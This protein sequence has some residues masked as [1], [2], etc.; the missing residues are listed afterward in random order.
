MVN[1]KLDGQYADNSDWSNAQGGAIHYSTDINNYENGNPDEDPE[2]RIVNSTIADNS[3]T[4]ISEN[5]DNVGG[6]GICRNGTENH[7]TTIFNSIIYGNEIEGYLESQNNRINLSSY[8]SPFGDNGAHINYSILEFFEETGLD[9]DDLMDTDPNFVGSGNYTLSNASVAIGAGIDEYEDIDAPAFDYNNSVRPNPDGSDPDLGAFESSLST[10]PYPATPQNLV[11][12]LEADSSI[13]LSWTAN[14]EDDLSEYR[15][16]YGTSSATALLDSVS[17]ANTYEAEGLDNYTTYYFAVSAMDLDGYESSKSNEVSG[18]PKWS[19]PIWY[20]DWNQSSGSGKDGSPATPFRELQDAIDMIA[21]G[22][23]IIVLPGTYNRT[24]DTELS[25]L[26]DSYQPKNLVLQSRDGAA[27]TILD[28]EDK[29]VFDISDGTDTT[30]QIIGFT[31]TAS[32]GGEDDAD[33]SVIKI[34]GDSYNNNNQQIIEYSGVTFKNCIIKDVDGED[35]PIEV[36]YGKAIFNDCEI[37]G[38][39]FNADGYD[40]DAIGGAIRIGA[41]YSSGSSIVHFYRSKLVNNTVTADQ[42]QYVHGGAIGIGGDDHDVKLVNTIVAGNSINFNSSNDSYPIG[43]GGIK[44]RGGNLLLINCTIADNQVNG[45]VTWSDASGSAIHVEDYLQDDNPTKLTIFNSIIY[46]NTTI[47][48]TSSSSVTDHNDQIY[49]NSDGND[50]AD[51]YASYS[52]FGGDDDLDGDEILLNTFPDFTDTTY[53]LHERS[54]AIGKGAT[55]SVD[56]EDETIYAPSNDLAGN[57]R[58]G[59]GGGDPDLGAY[60]HDLAVTPY[61]APLENLTA[62]PLHQSVLL[63]WDLH[64]ENNVDSYI[65]YISEDSITFTAVDTVTSRFTVNITI[66]N[67][68]NDEDYWFYVTAVN[69]SDYESLPSFHTKTTPF[70]QGPV[71]YVDTDNGSSS[72]DGSSGEPVRE[73]QDAIDIAA[74][75]DTVLVLPGTYDRADD[76]ELYFKYTSG[77]NDGDPKNIVLKSRDGAAVTILDGEGNKSLFEITDETD[78]TLQIIGFTIYNGGGDGEYNSSG[79]AVQIL[80]GGGGPSGVTFRNCIFTETTSENPVIYGGD[81][82]VRFFDCEIKNNTVSNNSWT[83][84]VIYFGSECNVF[85]NRCKITDNTTIAGDWAYGGAMFFKGDG[86]I[87]NVKVINSIIANNSALVENSPGSP[88]L[89]GAFCIDWGGVNVTV[90]NCTIVGNTAD[91]DDG[92]NESGGVASIISNNNPSNFTVLNSIMTDNYPGNNPFNYD[93]NTELRVSYSFITGIDDVG[94]YEDG[95]YNFEPDFL[96]STYALHPRS[97]AIGA[98]EVEEEDAEGNEI[99]A[100][101]IDLLGNARPN[102]ADSNPDLGAYEHELAVTA[103]PAIVEDVT[104]TPFHRSVLVEWDYHEE[105]DVTS[106]IAYMSSDLNTIPFIAIDTVEGRFNTRTTIENLTNG[107][108]YWFYVTAVDTAGYES[109]PTLFEQTSPFFQGPVWFVD[110]ANGSSNAE[111]SPE[112]PLTQIQDAID[113][114]AAGDTVLVLPGTYDSAD[115]Q[116]IEFAHNIVL[117]SRGGPDS[118]VIDCEG[119]S[120]AFLIDNLSDTTLKIIGFNIVNGGE[121]YTGQADDRGGSAISI[122]GVNYWIDGQDVILYSSVIFENCIIEDGDANTSAVFI[123]NGVGIFR[124]C[125]IRNNRNYYPGTNSGWVEGGGFSV[126]GNPGSALYLDRCKVVSNNVDNSGNDVVTQGAGIAVGQECTARIRNSLIADNY[127]TGFNSWS[128]A[129]GISVDNSKLTL[130]NTTITGNVGFINTLG[131]GLNLANYYV[132]PETEVIILNSIVAGNTPNFLQLDFDGDHTDYLE[133]THSIFE[134]STGSSWFDPDEHYDID[135][136]GQL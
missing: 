59:S 25:F 45:A 112:E 3:I 100:P 77:V 98:G 121:D 95:V 76:Q 19:G 1:N 23:T 92:D 113:L 128:R 117:M 124:D 93:N 15:I 122:Y 64:G 12:D 119:N 55:E 8:T 71:W 65:A 105:D 88:A 5:F 31:I 42:P 110:E 69:T 34:H 37:S 78:T 53:V 66:D 28:G 108:D 72:G 43:G 96:D 18:E 48:N 10:T 44:M 99:F 97:R 58:P 20:V 73:I 116:D 131:S 107:E 67:L 36:I 26:D 104:A 6:A 41:P 40:E 83:Y 11:V 13:T 70:Y 30:L 47:T 115:D 132:D 84:P 68:T 38:N 86:G 17:G 102:P 74:A 135:P 103:Y 33:G 7:N 94:D 129:A 32:D 4:D 109:S 118:T 21:A 60:E 85:I 35:S 120:R 111:G 63:E 52:L 79:S 54:P 62:T 14:S 9:E 125:I 81:A 101:T 130:I 87:T 89:G 126:R 24:D 16:Y 57:A 50:G 49:V 90:I 136:A 127:F 22:D 61:P 75:G 82:N 123:Y 134:G 91:N 2:L 56:V 114:T 80:G 29:R 133:M 106:Y 46:G 39:T 27:T 51:I